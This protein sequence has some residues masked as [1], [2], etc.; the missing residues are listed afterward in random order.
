M[1]T[2]TALELPFA[3]GDY[4]FD[5]KLIQLEEL[6][7]KRGAIFELAARLR[8]GR[9]MVMGAIEEVRLAFSHLPS[10]DFQ[11]M[12]DGTVL[13][14]NWD[15]CRAHSGDIFDTIRLGLIGGGRGMVGEK[16]VEVTALTARTLVERY[17]HNA[18][19]RESLSIAAAVAGA[20]VKGYTP[21][22][23]EPAEAPATVPEKPRRKRSTSKR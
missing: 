10:C 19:L 12:G 9:T 14:I 17:C 3:D 18:P 7:E 15:Q 1:P 13:V 22:K 6:Q 20:K 2:L 5:L 8:S 11:D 23:A 4:L 21:K 16:E